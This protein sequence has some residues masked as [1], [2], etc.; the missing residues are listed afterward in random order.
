LSAKLWT[1]KE[2]DFDFGLDLSIGGDCISYKDNYDRGGRV[3]FHMDYLWYSF[4]AIRSIERFPLYYGIGDWFNIG[5]SFKGLFGIQGVFG[6]T[7][8]PHSTPIDIS[9]ELVPA[10]QPTSSSGLGIDAGLGT[11][12]I[13]LNR[14]I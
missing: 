3:H 4:N 13:S 12:Y 9:F 8:F 14:R 11:I 6:I 7:W 1:S 2:N 5:G 10:L